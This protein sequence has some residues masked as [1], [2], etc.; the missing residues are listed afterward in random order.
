MRLV[1]AD[2]II[3]Q[4][5]QLKADGACASEDCGCCDYCSECWDGEMSES[6]IA[7]KAIE[8]VKESATD[9]KISEKQIP[10]KP[11]NMKIMTDFDGGYYGTKGDCPNCG[12]KGLYSSFNYC[13][14]CG[15]ALDWK[16][17]L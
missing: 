13:H 7:D 9:A 2:K 4:L 17:E 14:K 15:Q 10:K 16:G 5:E 11:D 1:D 3:E 8:I 12:R 6:L